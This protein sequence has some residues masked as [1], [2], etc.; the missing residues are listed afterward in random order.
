[1]LKSKKMKMSNFIKCLILA[2]LAGNVSIAQGGKN[3]QSININRWGIDSFDSRSSNVEGSVYINEE[4]SPAKISD[5]DKIYSIK[6]N[7]YHDEMIIEKGG[8]LFTLQKT[9]GFKVDF[10]QLKKTYKIYNLENKGKINPR[11]F[12][13]LV[14]G[15]KIALLAKEKIRLYDER[16]SNSGYSKHVPPTLK[17]INDKYYIG[18][19]NSSTAELPIKKKEFLKLFSSKSNEIN[20]YIKQNKLGI[21]KQNDLITIFKYYNK[22]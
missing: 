7:A 17:R 9:L 4:F 21:K 8:T 16:K 2:I 10:T 12:C 20:A 14:E 1:M 13:V 22:L 6:Y 11:F 18:F 3:N 5:T 19:S 15:N